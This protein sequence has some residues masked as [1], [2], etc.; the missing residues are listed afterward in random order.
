MI[1][2]RRTS[3]PIGRPAA[4]G[5]WYAQ[6][7]S[8]QARRYRGGIPRTAVD[9]PALRA[10]GD[11]PDG[12]EE[13]LYGHLSHSCG[14]TPQAAPYGPLGDLIPAPARSPRPAHLTRQRAV[15]P[16]TA[17]SARDGSGGQP[18]DPG[19]VTPAT[20]RPVT[21]RTPAPD[22]VHPSPVPSPRTGPAHTL[23]REVPQ[24]S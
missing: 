4:S 23:F 9:G 16:L 13:R 24:A 6:V 18:P 17:P 2:P 10:W 1:A 19:P 3:V 8:T 7:R 12:R 20:I 5:H 22:R 11:H 14:H 21:A 15:Q